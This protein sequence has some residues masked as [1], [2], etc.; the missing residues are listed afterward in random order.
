MTYKSLLLLLLPLWLLGCSAAESSRPHP[1][2][3]RPSAMAV[4]VMRSPV[5]PAAASVAL[6]VFCR[7]NRWRFH[8]NRC[9]RL[10]NV[11]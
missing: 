5:T 9:Y 3:W 10:T 11:F 2:P 1:Q 8:M 6:S 4:P 7:M